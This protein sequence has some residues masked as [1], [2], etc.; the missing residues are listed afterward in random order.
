MAIL[1]VYGGNLDGTH[2]VILATT[3]LSKFRHVCLL[4]RREGCETG[5]AEEIRIAMS[6][7]GTIFAKDDR[8][9]RSDYVRIGP[10][11]VWNAL[12]GRR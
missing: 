7:P 4:T 5:N 12:P 9:P 11:I 10:E 3:S 2:R 8:G 1:K 6:E